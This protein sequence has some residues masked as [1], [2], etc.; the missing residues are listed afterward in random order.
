[1]NSPITRTMSKSRMRFKSAGLKLI[2]LKNAYKEWKR[3]VRASSR[4]TSE[5]PKFG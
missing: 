2:N 3:P 1:M 5:I 4:S